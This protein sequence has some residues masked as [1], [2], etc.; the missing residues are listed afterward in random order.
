MLWK[1]DKKGRKGNVCKCLGGDF[2]LFLS[3]TVCDMITKS[4]TFHLLNISPFLNH[5]LQIHGATLIH[6]AI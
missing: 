2:F 4:V 6:M 5:H 3:P 1:I